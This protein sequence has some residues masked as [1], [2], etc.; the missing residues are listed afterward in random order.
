MGVEASTDPTLPE[1]MRDVAP[2]K[3]LAKRKKQS[4]S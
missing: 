4:A 1:L 3:V 2:E